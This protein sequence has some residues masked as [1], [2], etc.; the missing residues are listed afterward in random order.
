MTPDYEKSENCKLE[1]EYAQKRHKQ[2]IPCMLPNT[3]IWKAA[4]WLEPII[5][6]HGFIDFDNISMATIRSKV[7]EIIFLIQYPQPAMTQ[8][9]LVQSTNDKTYPFELIKYSFFLTEKS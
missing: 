5:R 6:Q 1:L 9:I 4:D 7:K 8:H 2:I 3:D